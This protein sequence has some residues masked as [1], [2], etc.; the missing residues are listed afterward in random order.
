MQAVHSELRAGRTSLAAG[1]R[2]DRLRR[3]RE[4]WGA[5][6]VRGGRRVV[7]WWFGGGTWD[8]GVMMDV[9]RRGSK[10]LACCQQA[11]KGIRQGTQQ[12]PERAARPVAP[13]PERA[14]KVFPA[15]AEGEA[16]ARPREAARAMM[17]EKRIVIKCWGP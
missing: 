11:G 16:A 10:V 2:Q 17:V 7:V 1:E 14:T 12:D 6:Q 8:V 4:R 3:E 9:R 15:S 5:A 13:S